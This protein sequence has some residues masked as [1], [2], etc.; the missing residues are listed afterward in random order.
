MSDVEVD[1]PGGKKEPL[2]RLRKVPHLCTSSGTAT[3]ELLDQLGSLQ[4]A[5][6]KQSVGRFAEMRATRGSVA[7][8]RSIR[9]VKSG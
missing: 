9:S 6:P 8:T 1:F 7:G 5:K 4:I 3:D 2:R